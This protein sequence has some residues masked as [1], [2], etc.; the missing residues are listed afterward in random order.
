MK[1]MGQNNLHKHLLEN[2]IQFKK[3]KRSFWKNTGWVLIG[4]SKDPVELEEESLLSEHLNIQNS[5]IL[6]GCRIGICGTCSI[7]ILEGQES[8]QPRNKRRKGVSWS[9]SFWKFEL[10]LGLP[11]SNKCKYSYQ[12]NR[13][14]NEY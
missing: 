9:S 7:E 3:F 8:L 11:N 6:F 4:N 1:L 5:P 2:T 14:L 10:P 13:D 12:K